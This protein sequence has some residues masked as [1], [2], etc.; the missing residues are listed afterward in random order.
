MHSLVFVKKIKKKKKEFSEE[1]TTFHKLKKQVDATH[2][3]IAEEEKILEDLLRCYYQEINPL[4]RQIGLVN[5]KQ[6][7][8]LNPYRTDKKLS[9]KERFLLIEH[10]E[11]LAK[12]IFQHLSFEDA[13]PE[14]KEILNEIFPPPPP[15]R[16]Q[17]FEE[18]DE[19]ENFTS[20]DEEASFEESIDEILRKAFAKNPI[21]QAV[22]QIEKKEIGALYKQ[23]A[24]AI[25]PDL[26][27]DPKKKLEKEAMMKKLSIAYENNDL[28][29]ILDLEISV[30]RSKERSDEQLKVYNNTLKAQIQ[31]L[32]MK[33]RTL[34]LQPNYA[35]IAR[36]ANEG[37]KNGK[38]IIKKS[39]GEFKKTIIYGEQVNNLLKGA[40]GIKTVRL[41]LANY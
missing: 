5:Q 21:E 3:K 30:G 17:T 16:E 24:K 33:L 27:Q 41:I 37:S 34:H 4:Q 12:N 13:S 26:E 18:K 29:T 2:K 32:K 25:H 28:H 10:M 23:L 19:Q 8:L 36:I 40:S 1:Q 35:P 15:P 11:N 39:V 20:W 14:F 9:K 38:V 7:L 22:H 6:F 31:E